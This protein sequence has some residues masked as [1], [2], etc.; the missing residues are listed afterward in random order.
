MIK[1]KSTHQLLQKEITLLFMQKYL[2]AKF[3]DFILDKGTY[4]NAMNF[5]SATVCPYKSTVATTT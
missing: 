3:H 5:S 4:G 2:N 1:K